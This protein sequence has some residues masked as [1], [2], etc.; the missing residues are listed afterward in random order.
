[1]LERRQQVHQN[2]L[3][4]KFNIRAQ[5]PYQR[6]LDSMQQRFHTGGFDAVTARATKH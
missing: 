5:P 2:Y 3:V 4:G 6:Y 1:M